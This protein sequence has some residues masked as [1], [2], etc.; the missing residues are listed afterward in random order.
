MQRD[1]LQTDKELK[2]LIGKTNECSR[3]RYSRIGGVAQRIKDD[4]D[5][6]R[7]IFTKLHNDRSAQEGRHHINHHNTHQHSYNF[8]TIKATMTSDDK[9]CHLM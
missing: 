7:M 6:L 3:S 2:S 5:S 4:V 8:S 9:W 1:C